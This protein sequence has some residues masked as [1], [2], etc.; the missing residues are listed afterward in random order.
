MQHEYESGTWTVTLHDAS[1]GGNASSTTATGHYT[2][3]GRLVTATFSIDDI[4]TTGMTG[5]SP[6]YIT[7]PFRANPSVGAAG[8]IVTDSIVFPSGRNSPVLT[9]GANAF[10]AM[11]STTG[12]GVHDNTVLVPGVNSG[13]GDIVHSTITYMT[14]GN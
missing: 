2:K 3:I 7:M 6:L 8:T 12:T 9:L 14:G 11:I 10:R 5:A 4:D 13:V 1:S